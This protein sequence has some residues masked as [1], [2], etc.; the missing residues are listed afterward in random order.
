MPG[1]VYLQFV[2]SRHPRPQSLRLACVDAEI[3]AE[4]DRVA[5]RGVHKRQACREVRS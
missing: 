3:E 1:A 4:M 5:G 2:S